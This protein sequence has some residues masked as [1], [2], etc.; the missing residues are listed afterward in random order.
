MC[1]SDL[2]T[3]DHQRTLTWLQ[4]ILE[5]YLIKLS[6]LAQLKQAD[7]QA[8]S[9]TCHLL[10]LVSQ[11][12]SSLVQRQQNNLTQTSSDLIVTSQNDSF[13][14]DFKQLNN[15]FPSAK[16]NQAATPA[17]TEKEIVN[18]ILVKLMP[19]YKQFVLRNSPSDTIIIDKLFESISMVLASNITSTSPNSENINTEIILNSL[20]EMFYCLNEESWRRFA[21]EVC[22]QVNIS[23]LNKFFFEK[24]FK[25]F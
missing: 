2:L 18:S 24:N 17:L 7:K 8:I 21:Y 23:F 11:L 9:V 13:Q 10:N 19:I 4:V 14:Q 3:I 12:M 22:R 1:L 5:P 16:S 6:E 15:S 25:Y 20:I